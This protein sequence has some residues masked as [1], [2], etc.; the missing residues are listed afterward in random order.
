ME[1]T[2]PSI[3]SRELLSRPTEDMRPNMLIT[4]LL[5]KAQHTKWRCASEESVLWTM[6]MR[7]LG[8]CALGLD[9]PP[10]KPVR[11]YVV[12]WED[13]AAGTPAAMA[14]AT[15]MF[16]SESPKGSVTH[17]LTASMYGHGHGRGD[18]GPVY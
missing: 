3:L 6:P 1:P 2:R 18:Y 15:A 12:C 8:R 16:H 13:R 11:D 5:Y 14:M 17:R 9:K 7:L 10:E 4:N